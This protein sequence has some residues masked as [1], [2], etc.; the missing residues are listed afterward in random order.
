M[1]KR[2]SSPRLPNAGKRR[3]PRP[4]DAKLERA[5][6]V[7][8][9]CLEQ[10]DDWLKSR[11]DAQLAD[12]AR[13]AF[14]HQNLLRVTEQMPPNPAPGSDEEKRSD[15]LQCL[16]HVLLAVLSEEDLRQ[17]RNEVKNWPDKIPLTRLLNNL[18]KLRKGLVRQ[19]PGRP[20]TTRARNAVIAPAIEFA[21]HTCDLTRSQA[22]DAIGRALRRRGLSLDKTTLR[23][24][25]N[26]NP[27]NIE[28]VRKALDDA[29]GVFSAEQKTIK[30]FVNRPEK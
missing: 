25:Y 24:I 6:D 12:A 2:L 29:A 14:A 27:S 9:P 26:A 11:M 5:A 15:G 20:R 18:L 21:R 19:G 10:Y 28:H 30:H 3:A 1:P 8:E 16:H 7:L 17:A 22:H 4:I 13:A 23:G